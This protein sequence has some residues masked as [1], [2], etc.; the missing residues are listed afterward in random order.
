MQKIQNHFKQHGY[1]VVNKFL[2]DNLSALLYR[3]CINKVKQVDFKTTYDNENYHEAYD[4]RFGDAQISGSYNCYGDVF[5]DSLLEASL[6]NMVNFTGVDLVPTYSYWR[7]YQTGD[8]LER[9]KDRE[10]CEISTTLCLGFNTSNNNDQT[11]NWPM[12]IK[13][14]D[15]EIPVYMQPGDMIIYRGCDIEHWR[16]PFKGLNHAQV[17]MH[18]NDKNGPYNIQFDGR[19]TLGL[20]SKFSNRK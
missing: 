19:P 17:F 13:T 1:V 14:K 10:S 7:F 18:Y 15:E 4:G 20:P 12:F 3:Y 6:D 11:Y 2:D 5:M 9:H 16:E 8:I